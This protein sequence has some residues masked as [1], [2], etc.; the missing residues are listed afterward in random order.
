MYQ[1]QFS[2]LTFL[3]YVVRNIHEESY[4]ISCTAFAFTFTEK[5]TEV[6]EKNGK[7]FSFFFPNEKALI[8]ISNN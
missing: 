3:T 1:E 5:F 4:L 6:V 8:A 7:F 2:F